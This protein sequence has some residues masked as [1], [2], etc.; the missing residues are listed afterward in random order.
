MQLI[1]NR[2]A[3]DYTYKKNNGYA[4]LCTKV[5]KIEKRDCKL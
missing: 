5:K 3:I 2:N 4:R 1:N